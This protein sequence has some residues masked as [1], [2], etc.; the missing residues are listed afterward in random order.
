LG[1]LP[2]YQHGR[3]FTQGGK[4]N[5]TRNVDSYRV[6]VFSFQITQKGKISIS[7]Q[8]TAYPKRKEKKGILLHLQLMFGTKYFTKGQVE[9]KIFKIL[10]AC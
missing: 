5:P 6:N 2:W 9:N 7:L 3:W 8:I 10:L 1:I 4:L